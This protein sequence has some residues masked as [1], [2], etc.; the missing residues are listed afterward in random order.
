MLVRLDDD[1][2]FSFLCKQ[3]S[4]F[5]EKNS[6]APIRPNPNLNSTGLADLPEEVRLDSTG[7]PSSR[8]SSASSSSTT[9]HKGDKSEVIDLLRDMQADCEHKK[10][11]DDHWREKRE[12]HLEREEDCK[13][14][15][16]NVSK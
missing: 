12:L 14:I 9:K 5:Y 1:E 4:Q 6:E 8:L 2:I 16:G 15:N 10:T 13:A 3:T 7:G 11:K